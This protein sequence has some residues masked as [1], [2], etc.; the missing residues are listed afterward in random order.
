MPQQSERKY[1]ADPQSGG[2]NADDIP[3]VIGVNDWINMENCRTGSTDAGYTGSV[4]SIG[5]TLLKSTPQPSATFIE[6]LA[7]P[8]E[9]NRRIIYLKY[10][11]AGP[12]HKITCYSAV[13][14]TEYTVLLSTQITGGLNFSKDIPYHSARI[15]GSMLYWVEGFHNQPRKINIDSGILLNHPSY[16]S[17]EQPYVAPLN[18]DEITVIKPP[19][20]LAP[21][22]QKA[23]D[24]LFI[25]NFIA[26]DSF[27]FAFSYTY[28]DNEET[29]VGTYSPASRLNVPTDNYNYIAVQ[30]D[31]G[32]RIPGT[33][34]IVS[35][36][37]RFGN[38]NNAKTVKT[39]D[40]RITSELAEIN[41]Q[42]NLVS[43]LTFNFYNNITGP[44]VPEDYVLKP[45]DNV[46]LYSKA[47][48]T[49]KNR[50]FLGNVIAGYNTPETTSLQ[51]TQ[52]ITGISGT[53]S[54]VKSLTEVRA[55][56]G[57]A[58]PNN[59]YGYGGWYVY[60]TSTDINVPGYYLL[61]GTEKTQLLNDSSWTYNPTL[62][63]PPSSTSIAGLTFIGASQAEVT[64]YIV[65]IHSLEGS[66][67]YSRSNLITITGITSVIDSIMKSR[68]SYK[69]GVVF[70]DFAM[71]KCGVVTNDGLV[72][73]INSRNYDYTVATRNLTW[74]LS[75]TNALAEI[76]D[77]AYWYTPVRTLNLRT[78]YFIDSF[79]KASK[80]ATKDADGNYEF[81]NDT[82]I[83]SVVG[84]G[85]D[86]TALVQSGLGYVFAAGD[87]AVLIDSANNSYELPVIDQSGNYIVVSAKDIGNLSTLKIIYEIYTPYQ[88][89]DQEPFFEVG[90][91]YAISNPGTSSRQYSQTTDV[92]VADSYTITRNYD[93]D[94]YAAEAM[95]PNDLFYKRWD[96]D[97][98][99]PNYITKLGQTAKPNFIYWSN[100]YIPGTSVNGL[101]TFEALNQTNV[102]EDCGPIQKLILTS[103]IQAEGTVML[104]ICSV[105]TNSIYLGETQIID[106]TGRTQFF[107]SSSSVISTINILKGSYGT[108]NPESVVDFRGNVFWLDVA[109]GKYIQYS[110]NGLFPISEYKATRFWKLFCD[111][112]MSTSA[113][114]IEALGS[115]PF[116]YSTVDPHHTELLVSIPKLSSTPP[117]GYL[118]DYPSTIYPFDIFDAQAKTIVYK[119]GKGNTQ[120][121][122]Q[123]SY[124]WTPEGFAVLEN[125]LYSFKNGQ[126]YIHNQ[127]S[128][129]NEFYGTQYKSKVMFVSNQAANIPKIYNSLGVEANI[130]PTLTYLMSEYP[131]LQCSDLMDYQYKGKEGVWY[132][133]IMRNK[134]VPTAGGFNTS[135][136]VSAEKMRSVAMLMELEFS[137][138]GSTFLELKFVTIN[139]DL[140]RGHKV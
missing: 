28:Y 3:A 117:K 11:T 138:S 90:Q 14:N 122:Y 97:G 70:Y 8:D 78:R 40:K 92:F 102:S 82:F 95:S 89:S 113:A 30:M 140:S 4:E 17:N 86:T 35:L 119:M 115:R 128:N 73:N 33:V 99:K 31:A 114:A 42:N 51:I 25:N 101:S 39:W 134:I 103:K 105:E 27:E 67:F 45:F 41:D 38:S 106:S 20:Q 109:N 132:A 64:T 29:V 110:A 80:Y 63:P 5:G 120:P 59:D 32:Q 49:A 24:S 136:L 124:N 54:I 7:I 131:Y 77:W 62:D 91:M 100:T 66:A 48:E 6:I 71:R 13:D 1:F 53:N 87:V 43:L 61:N 9:V 83:P 98:G 88:T 137:P 133:T 36:V 74:S 57:V 10:C 2:L 26:T 125:D 46:P 16:D 121:H 112:Y 81:T 123:G 12:F 96:N 60:L 116:V 47:L 75:N 50:L 18:F 52:N 44:A 37:V 127:T 15:V 104:A 22:I 84:I 85:L 58:G 21:N 79:S 111:L 118:L 65:G 107:S 55:K 126:L 135:G 76:P 68:S 34:K 139:F 72:V 129:T 94:T 69:V 56:V 93:S 23:Y 19:P 108:S 130:C